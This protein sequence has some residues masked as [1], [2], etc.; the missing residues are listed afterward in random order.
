VRGNADRQALIASRH[1]QVR[2]EGT[3]DY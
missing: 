2:N 3:N 1:N